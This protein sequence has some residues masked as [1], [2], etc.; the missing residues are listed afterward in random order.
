MDLVDWSEE[1]FRAIEADFQRMIAPLGY[2]Q[3]CAIP[4][5]ARHGDNVARHSSVMPWYSGQTILAHLHATPRRGTVFG[6]AFRMPV[7]TII[8]DEDFRGLAGT[9]NSGEVRAGDT[10][11]DAVSGR[12]AKVR[13]IVTMDGDLPSAQ[14]G[15]AVVLQL[16][17]DIDISRGAIVTA[18]DAPTRVASQIGARLVWLA[19]DPL[20]Q[21]RR[22][23]L[24]TAT[25]LV[26]VTQLSVESRLDLDTLEE[27]PTGICGSNDVVCA[28]MTL[29]RAVALDCF[30][31]NRETGSF[32][33]LDADS[34]NTLAGCVVTETGPGQS[35]TGAARFRLTS[36]MLARG[37]CEGLPRDSLEF[38][39]RAQAAADLL[40]TA[41]V[42]VDLQLADREL[43]QKK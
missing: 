37:V 13:R 4:V 39:R 10:V 35:S 40:A 1:R 6:G 38:T 33:L 43:V 16:D 3:A 15:Q 29:A 28:R 34:G 8:R 32:I 17:R 26:S 21:R 30:A 19:D 18:L 23:F 27:S 9:I 7:Q 5:S 12:H 20:D 2:V 42:A 14:A 24:R 31:A 25:D 41:G 11:R 22:L 36:E